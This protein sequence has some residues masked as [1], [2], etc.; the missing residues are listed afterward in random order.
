MGYVWRDGS[1]FQLIS[2]SENDVCVLVTSNGKSLECHWKK[3]N[4]DPAPKYVEGKDCE[5]ETRTEAV[6][7][8][9]RERGQFEIE[10]MYCCTHCIPV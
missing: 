1:P 4:L 2:E 10:P 7:V 3:A 9:Q 6:N 8:L 5:C